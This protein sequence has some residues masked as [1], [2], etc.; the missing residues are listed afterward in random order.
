[1]KSAASDPATEI[2]NARPGSKYTYGAIGM[3]PDIRYEKNIISAATIERTGE[4][5]D[6]RKYSSL[7]RSDKNAPAAIENASTKTNTTPVISMWADP[8]PASAIP[9]TKPTVETSESSTPKTKFL[10][11]DA[12]IN[13]FP[14]GVLY[15]TLVRSA[16]VRP[17]EQCLPLHRPAVYVA[18]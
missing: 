4:T 6:C 16:V 12:D 8:K 7:E 5:D 15:P 14:I 13:L 18:N 1:M 9:E 2:V 3:I 11:Y 10:K 17:M